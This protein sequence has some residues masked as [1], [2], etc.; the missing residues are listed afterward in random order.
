MQC[1][2]CGNA[3]GVN[4]LRCPQCG[5]K[6]RD[7][8][9]SSSSD[10]A[11]NSFEVAR[12][13]KPQ[14]EVAIARPMALPAVQSP[15]ALTLPNLPP[16][17]R[18]LPLAILM[19]VILVMLAAGVFV[20]NT[21]SRQVETSLE[22]RFDG[23]WDR[24]VLVPHF[25]QTSWFK[26]RDLTAEDVAFEVVRADGGMLYKGGS[27]KAT[28]K[29]QDLG[30]IEAITA[31]ACIYVT[32]WYSSERTAHCA[33]KSMVVSAK[34]FVPVSLTVNYEKGGSVD[35]P[36]IAFQQE[37]QR[38]VF[39]HE[40][41][42]EQI[43]VIQEPVRLKVWVANA[44]SDSV[45]VKLNPSNTVQTVD[46]RQGDGFAAFEES[47]L[48]A[49]SAD[50]DVSLAFQFFTSTAA[51]S[52][53]YQIKHV[54]LN[55][56]S[57]S[58]RFAELQT[59]ADRTARYMVSQYYAGGRNHT[60][61]IESWKF[62]LRTRTYAAIF[63]ISWNGLTLAKDKTFSIQGKF[64]AQATGLESRFELTAESNFGMFVEMA[65]AFR[66]GPSISVGS[67]VTGVL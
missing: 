42:W 37:L 54:V 49:A 64:S 60:A 39:G 31:K 43:R 63:T 3:L 66:G 56:K 40:D 47:Y 19:L 14:Q 18:T 44:P 51:D 10:S 22:A 24:I 34:R 12:V 32:P 61:T 23:S 50:T 13:S 4:F 15:T 21:V 11:A 8:S 9:D 6:L 33:T 30:N 65:R 35:T 36:G 67:V 7:R 59:M 29:D 45:Q 20:A 41:Q 53:A 26:S 17:K 1:T 55:G 2:N 62:D 57:E 38:S 48:R 28:L 58:E 27:P 52:T 16:P 25:V 5:L 46:L